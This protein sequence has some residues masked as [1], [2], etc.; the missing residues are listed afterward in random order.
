VTHVDLFWRD[1]AHLRPVP[2][3]VL[4]HEARSAGLVVEEVMNTSRLREEDQ[5][6]LLDAGVD[7]PYVA[8][9][10]DGFNAALVQLNE[11]LYGSTEYALVARRPE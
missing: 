5:L 1:P 3:T 8:K 6:K 10:V 7:D 9:V 2:P 11:L 4:A